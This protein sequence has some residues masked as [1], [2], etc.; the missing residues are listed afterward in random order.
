M[1]LITILTVLVVV[2]AC[3]YSS[4]VSMAYYFDPPTLIMLLVICIPLLW[5]SGL[6]KDFNNAF[7]YVVG[8]KEAESLLKLKKAVE[9]V[10]LTIK[11]LIFSGIMIAFVQ[12]TIIM[13]N[14]EDLASLGP[15][16]MAAMMAMV[17]ASGFALMLL[18]LRSQL[19]IKIMDYLNS[20]E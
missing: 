5:A 20:Q 6:L 14:L 9:A 11:I 8:K 10:G 12:V 17:Y 2:G 4:D 15:V 7:R 19:N 16:V 18:P 1:Y 13:R 3:Y